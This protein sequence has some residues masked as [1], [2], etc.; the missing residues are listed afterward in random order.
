MVGIRAN[1][2]V[3]GVRTGE[4][5]VTAVGARVGT[6]MATERGVVKV[7]AVPSPVGNPVTSPMSL[8]VSKQKQHADLIEQAESKF[9][10]WLEQEKL[11]LSNGAE[12]GHLQ[13]GSLGMLSLPNPRALRMVAP[14]DEFKD[15]V[16]ASTFFVEEGDA[17]GD[18]DKQGWMDSA[19]RSSG[20]LNDGNDASS[21]IAYGD[22][23]YPG[24]LAQPATNIAM[25]ETK[26]EEMPPPR[27]TSISVASPHDKHSSV[28][29][30]LTKKPKPRG[31]GSSAV[32]IVGE[33]VEARHDGQGA[34]FSGTIFAV[35]HE[36]VFDLEY[37]DDDTE[38]AVPRY[39]IRRKGDAERKELKEGEKVDARHEGGRGFYSGRIVRAWGDGTFDIVYDDD[40]HESRVPR[41]LIEACYGSAA[42]R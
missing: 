10:A 22:F 31:P 4:P 37:D 23:E 16:D 42:A 38:S 34:W 2:I 18:K 35:V 21:T 39:R 14:E 27:M 7:A 24:A 32:F 20:D 19:L 33:D 26:L 28:A 36:D 41:T 11:E 13:D 25:W 1:E 6:S 30:I 5:A 3:L 15:V 17:A 9:A 29:D 8:L 40:D 12:F